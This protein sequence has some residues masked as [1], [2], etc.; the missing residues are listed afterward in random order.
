MVFEKL[1]CAISG[2]GDA[3]TDEDAMVVAAVLVV[4]AAAAD[5]PPE[6]R[7]GWGHP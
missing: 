5:G 7:V 6:T 1:V 4:A 2:S 3:G